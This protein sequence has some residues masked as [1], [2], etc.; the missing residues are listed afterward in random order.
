MGDF[1][2]KKKKLC[3]ILNV[4]PHYR[5]GIFERIDKEYDAY[6]VT[7]TQNADIK[8][9]DMSNF[10]HP[11]VYTRDIIV[12]GRKIWQKGILKY[13]FKDYEDIIISGDI[14]KINHWIFLVVCKLKGKKTY[15]WT[16]GWYGK[17]TTASSWIKRRF[18]GLYYGL[19]LYGN[20][21][22]ELMIKEGFDKNRLFVIHNSLDY[23]HQIGMRKTILQSEVY[24]KHFG[25]NN[26]VIIFIGRLTMVKHLDMLIE[27]LPRI[28]EECNLV[29]VGGG[30][31]KEK[32]EKLAVE[33]G[34]NDRIWFYG[35]CYEEKTNAELIYN[36]D[37][38][39]APGNVGLTAMHTMVFGTPVIS[40]NCF[41]WQMPEYEAIK[42]GTTGDFFEYMNLQSMIDTIQK[43]FDN[44]SDRD[45]VRNA[46]FNEIDSYWNPDFQIEVIKSVIK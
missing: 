45:N 43:W 42:Q 21:A 22:K 30:V 13:A 33:K 7:G 46:C 11:V 10:R 9:L 37:L 32:L 6:F 15:A 20:H 27:A 5:K 26:K 12:K 17:E 40:H 36:A 29:F 16:H 44:H 34:L 3:L 38:C 31:E 25:N 4:A 8:P 2:T 35:P 14:R 28:K 23:E 39:V 18:Y 41:K 24:Q 1:H 19:F